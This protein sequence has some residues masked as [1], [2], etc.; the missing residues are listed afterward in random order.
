MPLKMSCRTLQPHQLK[1]LFAYSQ[2]VPPHPPVK[3]FITFPGEKN[4]HNFQINKEFFQLTHFSISHLCLWVWG[5]LLSHEATKQPPYGV[6]PRAGACSA[7]SPFLPSQG[8]SRIPCSAG[9]RLRHEQPRCFSDLQVSS[10]LA[11]IPN[12]Q[13]VAL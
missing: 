12:A 10:S 13:I 11:N 9:A 6:Y 3:D 5:G 1:S 4:I 2:Q 8:P 7:H